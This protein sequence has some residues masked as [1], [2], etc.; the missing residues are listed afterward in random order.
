VSV[1]KQFFVRRQW[2]HHRSQ[3]VESN[4][5]TSPIQ[6]GKMAVEL[7]AFLEARSIAAG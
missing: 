4:I 3:N 7:K 5:A 6:I 1:K 2:G